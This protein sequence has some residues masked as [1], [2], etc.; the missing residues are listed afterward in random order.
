V[1][2][3]EEEIIVTPG[4][5]VIFPPGEKHLHGATKDSEFSHISI[6]IAGGKTTW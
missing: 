2:T 4:T 6:Q 5:M 3:E 1:A